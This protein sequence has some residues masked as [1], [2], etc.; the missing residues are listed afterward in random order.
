M[1]EIKYFYISR[2]MRS[3]QKTWTVSLALSDIIVAIFLGANNMVMLSHPMNNW[4][5][6]A[7]IILN[8]SYHICNFRYWD[9]SCADLFHTCKILDKLRI[10]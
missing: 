4:V 10:Q 9:H 6:F 8:C 3:L 7:L 2:K 1:A 5:I